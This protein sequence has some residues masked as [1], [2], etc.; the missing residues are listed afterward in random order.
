LTVVILY[1]A[2]LL[3][4]CT[5]TTIG[6]IRALVHTESSALNRAPEKPVQCKVYLQSLLGELK[7][8]TERVPFLKR[9]KSHELNWG[10]WSDEWHD[11]LEIVAR[12]CR[13]K[14]ISPSGK[15]A[16]LLTEA[17]NNMKKVYRDILRIKRKVTKV[18]E[19][20]F[21]GIDEALKEIASRLRSP[22]KKPK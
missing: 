19:G 20:T 15:I 3:F 17:Y 22:M 13:L 10:K 4:M 16:R 11:R 14:V 7:D 5:C 21:A 8:H 6:I 2:F 12:A 9:D 1:W 18:R